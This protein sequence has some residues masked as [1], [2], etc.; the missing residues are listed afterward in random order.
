VARR[1]SHGSAS[2][3]AE[4]APGSPS[5]EVST[6][7]ARSTALSVSSIASGGMKPRIF[8]ISSPSGENTIVA[9]QPQSPYRSSMSGRASMST[10]TAMNRSRSNLP[11]SG[12]RYVT[13]SIT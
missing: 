3:G 1:K 7:A 8:P 2:T 13:S 4:V 11:T 9:G 12:F 10:F 6:R 5:F